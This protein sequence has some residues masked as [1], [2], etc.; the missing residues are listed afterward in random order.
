MYRN[1]RRENI[2]PEKGLI[3]CVCVKGVFDNPFCQ[4]QTKYWLNATE[5]EI[6]P[7]SWQCTV[8]ADQ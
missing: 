2:V 6:S 8:C 4:A 7:R 1:Y 3:T 5:T